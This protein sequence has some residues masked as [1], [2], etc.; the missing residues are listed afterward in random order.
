MPEVRRRSLTKAV[1]IPL[2]ANEK[3]TTEATNESTGHCEEFIQYGSVAFPTDIAQGELALEWSDIGLFNN[4]TGSEITKY[5][6]PGAGVDNRQVLNIKIPFSEARLSINLKTPSTSTIEKPCQYLAG[7][8]C[9][10]HSDRAGIGL[11]IEQSINPE[12]HTVWHLHQDFVVT[13]GLI[14]EGDSWLRPDEGYIEVARLRRNNNG[15]PVRLEV[16]S[17]I[18]RDYLCAKNLRLYLS[19]YRS[20]SQIL[21]DRNHIDW[22]PLPYYDNTETQRWEGRINEINERGMPYGSNFALFHVA[23]TDVD[24]EEDVPVL[25]FPSDDQTTSTKTIKKQTGQKLYR[26]EGELWRT[27]TIEPGAV[28][29]RIRFDSP[30]N[31]IVFIVDAAGNTESKDSLINGTSRWLWFNPAIMQEILNGRGAHIRWYTSNT[32]SIGMRPG[33]GVPFGVNDL[34]LIN[35]Y[36]K[37]I[38]LLNSWEQR[39]WAGYNIGPDGGVSQELLDSQMRAQ[40]ANTSAPEDHLMQAYESVNKEFERVTGKKLFRPHAI[41]DELFFKSHRF[42][43]MDRRG[44][45]EL[46][47]DLA[48]LVVESIDGKALN[49]IIKAPAGTKTGSVKHLEAVLKTKIDEEHARML[50]GVFIGINE[51]RQA[52]AH[53]PSADL[54]NSISLAGIENI[55]VPLQEAEQMLDNLVQSLYAIERT[56]RIFNDRSSAS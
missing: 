13:L 14:R 28:S 29:E 35:I 30:K 26:I 1:W 7:E 33:S 36:A 44:L 10:K 37:D 47:K 15:N 45:F 21:L 22:I 41:N 16:K 8:H 46:A 24:D 20:R 23:R 42:R 52:D 49:L 2:R 40:P 3:I 18:L 39:K 43:A 32:G 12:E 53:L 6:H 11:V 17:D 50:T 25:G 54:D 48:R 38:G 31:P 4:Y 55:G 27:E 9:D 34:G 19:S 51:L 56:L 5:I